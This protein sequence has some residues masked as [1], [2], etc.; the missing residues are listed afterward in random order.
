MKYYFLTAGSRHQQDYRWWWK[1]SDENDRLREVAVTDIPTIKELKL[2]EWLDGDSSGISLILG[3]CDFQ[4]ELLLFITNLPTKRQDYQRRT[5]KTSLLC[6]AKSSKE[7]IQLRQLA[8]AVL[9]DAQMVAGALDKSLKEDGERSEFTFDLNSWKEFLG[10]AEIVEQHPPIDK[11]TLNDGWDK[12]HFRIAKDCSERREEVRSYLL[13]EIEFPENLAII[14]LLTRYKESEFYDENS[15]YIGAVLSE[16]ESKERW[17]HKQKETGL[18]KIIKNRL[19]EAT[20][21][22]NIPSPFKRHLFAAAFVIVLIVFLPILGNY[23]YNSYTCKREFF[24]KKEVYDYM[25]S[26]FR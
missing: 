7:Y 21:L 24:C 23:F 19:Q 6:I 5:I 16:L 9:S 25:L 1:E 18:K 11:E 4:S 22:I 26:P 2:N 3:R 20:K 17:R 14:F 10:S 12:L 15:D 8:S 13:S